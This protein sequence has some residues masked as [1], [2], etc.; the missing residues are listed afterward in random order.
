MTPSQMYAEAERH[1]RRYLLMR[2]YRKG[3]PAKDA[4]YDTAQWLVDQGYAHWLGS[5]NT[6]APGIELTNKPYN[7]AGGYDG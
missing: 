1:E 5:F 2:R 6:F 4:L 3:D 7:D